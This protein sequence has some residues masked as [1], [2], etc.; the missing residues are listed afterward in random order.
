MAKKKIKKKQNE[1]ARQMI[2]KTGSHAGPHQNN[3]FEVKK[4]RKRHP[5]HKKSLRREALDV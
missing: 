3:E 2:L 5:K 1:I 4:G